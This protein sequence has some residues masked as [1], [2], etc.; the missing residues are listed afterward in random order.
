[1]GDRQFRCLGDAP[2]PGQEGFGW[3]HLFSDSNPDAS[4]NS[5]FQN[6]V[7]S[8]YAGDHFIE[9][10]P[11]A[12][13]GIAAD[14]NLYSGGGTWSVAAQDVDF[15][16]WKSGHPWDGAS[17][18]A[19]AMLEDVAEFSQ[20]VAQKPVYDWKKAAP[21]GGSPLLGAGL[22]QSKVT[23]DFTGA[24]R[25]DGAYDLGAVAKP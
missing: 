2:I 15:S 13:A 10:Q 20:T 21:R 11:G 25:K 19:D 1:M 5:I 24:A 22:K 16:S 8:L 18:T 17:L 12:G 23:T 6:N 7:F 3:R 4:T 9:V 14:H